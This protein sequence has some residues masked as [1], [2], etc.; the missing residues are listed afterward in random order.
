MSLCT[1]ALRSAATRSAEILARELDS[2]F[3]MENRPEGAFERRGGVENLLASRDGALAVLAGGA[4]RL[5]TA[6]DGEARLLPCC[7]AETVGVKNRKRANRKTVGR[8]GIPCNP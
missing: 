7:H 8:R 6:C 2:S 3:L 5:A 4:G 1:R